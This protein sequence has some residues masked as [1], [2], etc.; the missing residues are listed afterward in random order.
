MAKGLRQGRSMASEQAIQRLK[1]HLITWGLRA[2]AVALAYICYLAA[3]IGDFHEIPITVAVIVGLLVAQHFA[4]RQAKGWIVDDHGER[5]KVEHW[6]GNTAIY[7]PTNRNARIIEEGV[8][9]SRRRK[10]L[11]WFGL[12]GIPLGY[13][14]YTD[15]ANSDGGWIYPI[16]GVIAAFLL[17]RFGWALFREIFYLT[18]FQ[19]MQGA[20]V[21]DV[22]VSKPGLREVAEQKVHG[23]ARAA[24]GAEANSILN[25]KN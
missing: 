18:G 4:S 6:N 19:D 5:Q 21:M 24:S 25:R 14:A 3:K 23:D 11:F 12:T 10:E 2:F 1:W 8:E 17:V 9:S 7:V 15:W 20:R 16:V 22:T 13:F